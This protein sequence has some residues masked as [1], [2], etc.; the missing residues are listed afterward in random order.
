MTAAQER[1]HG[2]ACLSEWLSMEDLINQVKQRCEEGTMIPSKALVR[3]QFSP[4]N[5][6]TKRALQFTNRFKIQ[7]KIQ[8]RQL[9]ASHP[10]AHFC[11][12][13]FKY[14]RARAIQLRDHITILFMD[15]KA[16]IPVGEPG[17]AVSTGVRG[18][19]SLVPTDTTLSALDHDVASIGSFATS[20]M[21]KVEIPAE[22]NKSW[23][24]G[25]VSVCVND[26]VFECAN[27]FRNAAVMI[28]DADPNNPILFKYSD[29]GVEHRN[30]LIKVQLSLIAVFKILNLDLLVAARCAPGQSW[31]NPVER[32]M[33]I[34][35]IGLQNVAT[36]RDKSS[37]EIEAILKRC[38]SMAEIR[39]TAETN[40]ELRDA[41]AKSVAPVSEMIAKRFERLKLK[42][43]PF[44]VNTPVSKEQIQEVINKIKNMF[45][46]VDPETITKQQA[47]TRRNENLKTWMEQHCRLRHYCFQVQK[48]SN[49]ECCP[50]P[51]L[52][53]DMLQWLPDPVKDPNS[54]HYLPLDEVLGTDTS[55]ND[56]PGLSLVHKAKSRVQPGMDQQGQAHMYTFMEDA[57]QEQEKN[58]SLFTAQCARGVVN[59]EECSKPR[60]FYSRLKLSS[61]QSLQL[62]LVLSELDYTCGSPLLP[63]SHSLS[64]TVQARLAISCGDAIE[65]TFYSSAMGRADTCSYCGSLGASL[66][67]DLCAKY[68][69]VL[70]CCQTCLANGKKI[71]IARPYSKK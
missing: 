35:N 11:A 42:G 46:E 71:I 9:R 57:V 58:T 41:W 56:R 25:Q 29:G 47:N 5:P 44:K 65:F 8:V 55:D 64:K 37:H 10:D 1:R 67:H 66:D 62:S 52:Q 30:V 69:T 17:G 48:C 61:R 20:V 6:Y 24:R 21:L 53:S 23:Y 43:E 16:K 32:V 12:A 49:P 38:G 40:P 70:P 31:V 18:R 19:Q 13:L 63:E 4:K 26:A 50:T 22:V 33:A 39:K 45:P 27:P 28:H 36:E 7:Y 51:R 3:L 59:C 60:M 2:V 34:L 68:K 14:L 15:D 54:D